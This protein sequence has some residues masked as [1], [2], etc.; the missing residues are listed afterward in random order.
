MSIE[1][2]TGNALDFPNGANVLVHGCNTLGKFGAGIA[3]Q[4]AEEYPAA[5]E[6]YLQ[7]FEN[8]QIR[9]GTF[10]T[11]NVAG[12]KRIVNLI[13]QERVGADKRQV[14]YEALYLGLETL[15]DILEDAAKEGRNYTVCLPWIGTGLAG[16]SKNI[17]KAIFED[18]FDKSL[19]KFIIVDYSKSIKAIE[20]T[21]ISNEPKTN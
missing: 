19:I 4:I 5:K 15:K 18:I 17:I 14:D 3:A 11:A 16:G 7:A 10:T 1:Y 6:V 20:D 2:F 13:T 9:L 21:K 12:G 8:K